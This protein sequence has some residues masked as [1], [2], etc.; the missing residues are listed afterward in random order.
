MVDLLGLVS[1]SFD[2]SWFSKL[3][4]FFTVLRQLNQNIKSSELSR[5]DLI[6][7]C[8]FCTISLVIIHTMNGEIKLL[9]S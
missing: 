1:V 6:K 9:A 5:A 4:F 2:V 3:I 7:L 8:V